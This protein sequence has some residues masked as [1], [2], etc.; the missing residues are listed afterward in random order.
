MNTK[1]DLESLM[2]PEGFVCPSCGRRHT[3][4]LRRL[5]ISDRAIKNIP[6]IL[7]ELGGKEPFVLCDLNTYDAA[8]KDICRILTDAGLSFHLHVVDQRMPKPDERIV[9][10]ALMY[11][12]TGADSVIGVGGGVIN[13]TCKIISAAKKCPH[14]IAATAPSMDGFA[15]ATSSMDRSGLKVSLPSKCAD[16]V[17]GDLGILAGAPAKLISSGVGD[18]IAKYTSIAEW[19]ISHII[20]EEYFCPHIAGMVTRALDECVSGAEKAIHGDKDACGNVMR[21]LLVAGM[22]MNAAGC[23]RPASGMEHYIS[24]IIDMRSLAFGTPAELHGIQCALATLVTVRSYK[25]LAGITPDREK[26]LAY[27]SSFDP[28]KWSA[29]LREKLGAGAEAMIAGEA[30][31]HK[32][33]K[34]KHRSRLERIIARWNEIKAVID[35]MPSPDELESLMRR[36]GLPVTPMEIGISDDDLHEAFI[37]AKDMRDK[38]VLGRL[39]WDLG[40]LA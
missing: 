28:D 13:D 36:T 32:Y 15:S 7:K 9:G 25:K 21:G 27:V 8:G 38:Y 2:L 39:L 30:R 35:E 20:N 5:D 11:C 37:M 33:D 14:I 31:E 17:V 18:M 26:A 29:H 40:L 16:A 19:K 22:A 4:G 34:E 3:G 10:E 12:P 6:S 23:S 1:N 24:H